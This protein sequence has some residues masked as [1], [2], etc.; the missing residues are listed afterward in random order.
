MRDKN[1]FRNEKVDSYSTKLK[2]LDIH[3]FQFSVIW[4]KF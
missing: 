3:Y 1:E 4:F 2:K